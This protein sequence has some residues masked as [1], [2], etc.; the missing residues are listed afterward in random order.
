MEAYRKIII[1]RGSIKRGY[2]IVETLFYRWRNWRCFKI[3]FIFYNGE[4]R[5]CL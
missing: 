5:N 1:R 4:L 3:I 2:H